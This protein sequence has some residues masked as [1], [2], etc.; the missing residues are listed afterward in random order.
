[1]IIQQKQKDGMW[2]DESGTQIPVNRLTKA[3]KLMERHSYKLLRGAQKLNADLAA[4]K[5]LLIDLSNE[6]YKVFMDEKEAKPT[7]GNFTWYNFNR[8]IKI[9][10]SINEKIEFDD[11]TIEAA[12]AR[13][14]EFLKLNITSKNEFVKD[15]ILDA[16]QTKQKGKLDVKR[17]LQLTRY[18]DRINDRLFSEAVQLINEGIR[19]PSSKTYFRIWLKDE[20]GKYHN[21]DLNL[22]SIEDE[23]SN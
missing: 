17:V 3:E 14:D 19:R 18:E 2:T 9:E 7:K 20:S 16:F 15:M 13:F 21:I 5:Q 6:A 23:R 1:M 22:S 4:F 12:K 10:V 11:L 8:S